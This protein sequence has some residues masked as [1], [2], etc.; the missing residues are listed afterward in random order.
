MEKIGA[1]KVDGHPRA[2]KAAAVPKFDLESLL[3][4][5]GLMS[6]FKAVGPIGREVFWAAGFGS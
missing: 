5:S 4:H 2:V 3:S 1:K 6:R